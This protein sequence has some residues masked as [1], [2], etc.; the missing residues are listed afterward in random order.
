M[1]ESC[2]KAVKIIIFCLPG[3]E[4]IWFGGERSDRAEIDDVSAH[5]RHQHLLNVGADLHVV[6]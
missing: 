4:C 6:T 3:H 1:Y 5:L 2:N